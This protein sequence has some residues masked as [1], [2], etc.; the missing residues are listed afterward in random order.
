MSEPDGGFYGYGADLY[1]AS[2]K[3]ND[4]LS[5]PWAKSCEILQILRLQVTR[6]G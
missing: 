6:R 4:F 1:I 5:L 2:L 3:Q